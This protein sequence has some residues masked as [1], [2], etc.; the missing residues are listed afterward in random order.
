MP[1]T[2]KNF[3]IFMKGSYST[4]RNSYKYSSAIRDKCKPPTKNK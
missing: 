3:R 1:S 2:K 4:N